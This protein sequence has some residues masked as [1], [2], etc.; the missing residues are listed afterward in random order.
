MK[1]MQLFEKQTIISK[2]R[3][4]FLVHTL[5]VGD[6]LRTIREIVN[7]CSHRNFI[8][9]WIIIKS[10]LIMENMNGVTV[11]IEHETDKNFDFYS[12]TTYRE[13]ISCFNSSGLT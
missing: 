10:D 5:V 12:Q 8:S 13:L 9:V 4:T 1:S 2:S 6:E 3:S 11:Y 7:L